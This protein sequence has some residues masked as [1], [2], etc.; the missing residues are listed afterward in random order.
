MRIEP[1]L[2][3]TEIHHVSLP[4]IVTVP[5]TI[6][7][8]PSNQPSSRRSIP[9]ALATSAGDGPAMGFAV[10]ESASLPS[11]YLASL[12]CAFG[13]AAFISW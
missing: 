4:V 5:R 6:P 12:A 3:E 11:L 7:T 10:V 13:V 1:G 9:F 2:S 8:D